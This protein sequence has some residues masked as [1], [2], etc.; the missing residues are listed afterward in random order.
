MLDGRRLAR[1][2]KFMKSAKSLFSCSSQGEIHTV[3]EAVDWVEKQ[4]GVKYTYWGMRGVFHR[5]KL[6]NEFETLPQL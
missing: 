3:W 4:F 6:K 5:L 2:L 1:L